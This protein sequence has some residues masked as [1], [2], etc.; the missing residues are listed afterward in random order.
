MRCVVLLTAILLS[1]ECYGDTQFYT[2]NEWYSL[3]SDQNNP[4]L[5]VYVAGVAEVYD[6]ARS[7]LYCIPH[8]V[9]TRQLADIYCEY[10]K[11]IPSHRQWNAAVLATLS[12]GEAYPCKGG[13]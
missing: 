6:A 1:T 3:C 10:L 5:D 12:F 4:F 11:K 7:G 13:G 9:S 8:G 2:G